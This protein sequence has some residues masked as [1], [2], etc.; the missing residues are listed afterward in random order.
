VVTGTG[1]VEEPVHLLVVDA[2]QTGHER[3]R[4]E[5][6][7]ADADAVLGRQDRGEQVVR[8]AAQVEGQRP[9]RG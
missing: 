8:D 9:T 7:V 6:A 1:L 2:Q 5:A 4:A 3:V